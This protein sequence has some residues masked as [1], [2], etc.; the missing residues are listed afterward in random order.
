MDN[1]DHNVPYIFMFEGAIDGMFVMNASCVSGI[2]EEG[3]FMLTALQQEQLDAHPFHEIVWVLD[4][5]YLDETAD[6]KTKALVEKGEKVFKWPLNFGERYKDFND[7]A[8]AGGSTKKISQDFILGNLYKRD[9]VGD[10]I[11]AAF[12]PRL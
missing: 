2:T 9:G 10:Q 7:I 11:A 3:E 6:I 1:I 8:I 12:M 4:S 5:P